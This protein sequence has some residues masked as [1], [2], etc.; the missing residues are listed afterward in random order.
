MQNLLEYL[1]ENQFVEVDLSE[2]QMILDNY[3]IR[4]TH[5]DMQNLYYDF[6]HGALG[7]GLYFL[8][9]KTNPEFLEN[10]LDFLDQTAEKD[11][12]KPVYKWKSP[13]GLSR[14]MGYNI[15][16]SHGIS[17]AADYWMEQTLNH[18]RFDDG[19]AGYKSFEADQWTNSD[20]LLTGV[21]GIGLVMISCL[22]KDRQTWDELFLVS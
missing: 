13:L 1:K 2:M 7:S 22:S 21:A 3:L 4:E 18:S 9:A 6:M 8:K 5:K 14:E 10:M 19:L 12:V 15:S 17:G 20:S 11:T 16:L